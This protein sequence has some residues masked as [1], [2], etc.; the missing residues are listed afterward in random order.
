VKTITIILVALLVCACGVH[1]QQSAIKHARTSV[2]A[3]DLLIEA[4]DMIVEG[5]LEGC[6][7]AKARVVLEQ[8]RMSNASNRDALDA[9]E[10]ALTIY[11]GKK[12]DGEG[13]DEAWTDVLNSQ[14]EWFVIAESV[15]G[16]VSDIIASIKLWGA[17][18]PAWLDYVLAF[19]TGLDGEDVPEPEYDWSSL[20]PECRPE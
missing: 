2:A 17:K 15:A 11:R 3:T 1:N 20:P 7:Q 4:T 6:D 5:S 16:I 13:K 10:A 12:K 18:L 19:I 14:S 8:A 9:W